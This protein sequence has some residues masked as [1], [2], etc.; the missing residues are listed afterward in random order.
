MAVLLKAGIDI[1][2]QDEDG[3]SALHIATEN[4]YTDIVEHLIKANCMIIKNKS[5]QSPLDIPST[6]AIK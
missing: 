4:G 2:H 5:N 6:P 3:N 1:D